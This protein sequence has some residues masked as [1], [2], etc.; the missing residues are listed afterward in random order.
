MG[1][2]RLFAGEI[3]AIIT[4]WGYNLLAAATLASDRHGDVERK[5]L[6]G[7][8]LAGLK[9]ALVLV[10]IEN[11]RAILASL[12]HR[13]EL[14]TGIVDVSL[15]CASAHKTT[16]AMIDMAAFTGSLVAR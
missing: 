2:G 15:S 9:A 7:R 14:T 3:R 1:S 16:G 11:S 5:R 6:L 4:A 13:V 8:G 10:A 12:S